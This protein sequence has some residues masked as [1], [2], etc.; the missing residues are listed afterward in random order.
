MKII[1]SLLLIL[2]ASCVGGK[3]VVYIGSTP[4][5][6]AVV[7][8]FLGIP[9]NDS[10]DFIKWKLYSFN[11]HYTLQCQFGIGKPNTD[12]FMNDGQKVELKGKV[13]KEKNYWYLEEGSKI[14]KMLELNS[15]LLHLL[16][17][18]NN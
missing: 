16:D 5:S 9:L 14:L 11:D 17:G 1:S 12:G 15:N 13:R 6:S 10:V 3:E 18:D 7:R 4:A 8:N 2:L